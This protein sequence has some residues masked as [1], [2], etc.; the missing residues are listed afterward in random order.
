LVQRWTEAH[1][2]RNERKLEE[3]YAPT[4]LYYGS[5]LERDSC[6]ASKARFLQKNPA[7]QQQLVGRV[8][9]EQMGDD[10]RA[11]FLKRVSLKTK[12]ADYPSYLVF[13]RLG[14]QWR[15][16]TEGDEVTDANL[17]E[18]HWRWSTATPTCSP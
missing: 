3:L 11:S 4:V 1:N 6:L 9:H 5:R 2:A 7:F 14:D 17:A 15:I 16:V 12:T 18:K 13:R 10:L 8:E